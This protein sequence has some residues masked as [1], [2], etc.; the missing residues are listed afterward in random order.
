MTDTS[1]KFREKPFTHLSI[2]LL[3]DIQIN[4]NAIR[5]F[6]LAQNLLSHCLV[7]ANVI[8][9]IKHMYNL[10][11]TSWLVSGYHGKS[12]NLFKYEYRRLILSWH[13]EVI[14]TTISM[15]NIFVDHLHTVFPFLV[16]NWSYIEIFWKETKFS[17]RA[18]IFMKSVTASWICYPR[19]EEHFLH[20]E[21]SIVI[22]TQMLKKLQP[23]EYLSN[24]LIWWLSYLTLDL[25][26]QRFL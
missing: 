4:E 19:S 9:T 8:T 16:T 5:D 20:W 21:L 13:C 18:N 1:W 2:M 7:I 14:D 12:A 6:R 15:K 11:M 22:L 24:V 3:A 25:E 10:I 23:Y 26:K 17:C